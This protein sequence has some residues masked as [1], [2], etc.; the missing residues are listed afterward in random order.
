MS[1]I[2]FL[3]GACVITLGL[4]DAHANIDPG[5]G[6]R[7]G[8]GGVRGFDASVISNGASVMALLWSCDVRKQFGNVREFCG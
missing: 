1:V 7:Y 2:I 4:F 3:G 8:G 6:S 5:S